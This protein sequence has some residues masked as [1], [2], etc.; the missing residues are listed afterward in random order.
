VAWYTSH[1]LVYLVVNQIN[2]KCYIGKTV[3]PLSRRWCRHCSIASHGSRL[4]FH[5]AI[6]KYGAGTFNISV[7]C[8]APADRLGVIEQA[9]IAA[10]RAAHIPLYNV[11]E[12]GEGMVGY[13]HSDSAR[14]KIGAGNRGKPHGTSDHALF[15]GHKHSAESRIKMSKTRKGRKHSTETKARIS[16]AHLGKSRAPFSAE[17][18][19]KMSAAQLG[20]HHTAATR[21]KMAESGRK[22]WVQRHSSSPSK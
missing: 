18:L 12:G 6:R 11:T 10:F 21:A 9:A 19:A 22:L 3:T 17:T 5:R 1:V 2:G 16:T 4:P 20:R 14:A 13:K 15:R 8:Y 7:L